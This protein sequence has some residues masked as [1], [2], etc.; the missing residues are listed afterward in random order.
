MTCD[1]CGCT[2]RAINVLIGF[3]I[4]WCSYDLFTCIAEGKKEKVVRFCRL[5]DKRGGLMLEDD[6]MVALTQDTL[7]TVVS[8]RLEMIYAGKF[9]LCDKSI[10]Q[11]ARIQANL[12]MLKAILA[13][14][15][16]SSVLM[17]T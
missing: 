3:N 5:Y 7:S 11:P 9:Y 8:H 10:T 16:T 17:Q 1:P 6:Y 15:T 12:K 4:H 14:A 2:A 13:R